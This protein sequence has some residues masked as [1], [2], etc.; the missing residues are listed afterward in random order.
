VTGREQDRGGN[1]AAPCPGAHGPDGVTAHDLPRL[2]GDCPA[3]GIWAS[4]SGHL[5]AS[6]PAMS[7]LLPGA[8]ITVDADDVPGLR[9]AIGAAEAA[10]AREATTAREDLAGAT[11]ARG[12][13]AAGRRAGNG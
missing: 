13:P 8:A 1:G 7:A 6:H 11:A 12:N 9:A 3:W 4:D 5:Y 2:R 10:A